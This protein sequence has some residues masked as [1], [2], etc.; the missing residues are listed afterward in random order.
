[1][2]QQR[3]Q[4]LPIA[5][6]VGSIFAGTSSTLLFLDQQ[7]TLPNAAAAVLDDA[8]NAQNVDEPQQS[9]EDMGFDT[10]LLD[11][12]QVEMLQRGIL[13]IFLLHG[14]ILMSYIWSGVSVLDHVSSL[15]EVVLLLI[16]LQDSP[17]EADSSAANSA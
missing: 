12:I 7:P 13:T 11:P 3:R 14:M 5:D 8:G 2:R 1:M 16:G 6:L 10:A 9:L 17:L 15:S 4:G